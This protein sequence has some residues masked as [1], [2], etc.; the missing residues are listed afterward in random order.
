MPDITYPETRRDPIVEDHFGEQIADPYR[1]LEADVRTAPEV[2]DWVA[3][4]NAVTEDYLAGLPQRAHFA[5]RVRAFMEYER[6][7]LPVKAGPNYFYTRNS[8]LQNQSQL[9]VRK[10]LS[11]EPRLLIDPNGWA[12]DGATALDAWEP[13]EKGRHLLYSVQDGGSDWR[14]LRVLDVKTG[15]PMADEIRWAK[16]TRLA[17]V[18]EEGF[19]YSRFPAPDQGAA[20][21]SLNYNQAVYF[22]RLGTP[23]DQDE[24]VYATPDHPDY[25]HAA[26]VT[27]D[28]RLAIITSHVGTDARYEV[29]V[30]DLAKRKRDGWKAWPL[31]T[32]FA[33]DW[34]L[35]EGA[36]RRLWFVTN[37]DAPRYRL[38]S[39]DLDA[40]VPEWNEVVA[41]REDILERAGIVG[42][43]LVLNYMRDAASHAEIIGLDGSPGRTLT[44]SGIGTASGFRGRPG[45]P[46]TFYA[47]TSFNCPSAIYR[48]NI[49]TGASEPFAQPSL[50]Y[51]PEAY[52][53]EQRF[54]TSKD[55]TRVPMFIVR[56]RAVAKAGKP[57][58]TLLYGYGGF[59]V[60]L[61]PGF[62]ATRMAWL[63][64]GG[65]FA[66]ANLRGGGE[67]GR[68]WHDAGRRANKQNVFDD[69]IAAGEFLIGQGIAKKDGLAIQGGS[70]GGLLVGAVVN[71]RPDL[72]AAAV[73]QVGVMD[74]L[75]FDRFTAGRYWVDD[76][77][78]PDREA[79]FRVLRAY[80]PYHNIRDGV[81][82]PAI[83]VTTADT[84]DRVVPGHSFKYAAALQ[85]ADLGGKPHIIRIETRAG[86]GSGKP[87][88]KVI[89]EGADILSFIA[90][91]TALTVP[92]DENGRSEK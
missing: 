50:C 37:K 30:V 5:G 25:G 20:F 26:E 16:F 35:V 22:H 51:D 90:Q 67:Y 19:L 31:V 46:E 17:W 9:F 42:D 64:A 34:K 10:G 36:G 69:F 74:M 11:G 81:A 43:Q 72:F 76:Y 41:Q 92:K 54:Y 73:A 3:R 23:Q 71:Q 7:G 86:H 29:H 52:L 8:G 12:L 55:G 56:S 59:D 88:D 15:V 58:P 44:L 48:M 85:A 80:S 2:A 14:I 4:E 83:L 53:V 1:W 27:Q 77:G 45:D 62:S 68:E 40:A 13:S 60:A 38:V 49:A 87:T 47:F 91:W 28:G 65:A 78:Y 84:D 57:V 32:G 6:F 82:Y 24:L 21:Q 63:E 33:D 70:N 79:D 39:I 75:R 89:E 18:G 66:L 61:T